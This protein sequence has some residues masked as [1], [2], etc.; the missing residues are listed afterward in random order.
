MFMRVVSRLKRYE[1]GIHYVR[2]EFVDGREMNREAVNFLQQAIILSF[3]FS[4]KK[5]FSLLGQQWDARMLLCV[6]GSR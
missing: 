3:Q 1:D 2:E 5:V 6:E 4:K